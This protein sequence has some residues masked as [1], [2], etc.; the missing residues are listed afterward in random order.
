MILETLGASK[1]RNMLTGK[2]VIKAGKGDVRAGAGCMPWIAWVKIFSSAPS[3]KQN[4]DY[5]VFQLWT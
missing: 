4:R 1:L 2:E 3:F 5:Y